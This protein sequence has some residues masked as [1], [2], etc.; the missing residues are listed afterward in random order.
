[1]TEQCFSLSACE[2][3]IIRILYAIVVYQCLY[4]YVEAETK[5]ETKTKIISKLKYKRK[6]FQN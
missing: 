5:T 6:L 3:I 4:I 1:M 2:I